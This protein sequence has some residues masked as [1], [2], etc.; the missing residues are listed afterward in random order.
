MPLW[1]I[2]L[3]VLVLAFALGVKR[4][5][6]YLPI[7]KRDSDVLIKLGGLKSGQTVIDLG[8]GDGR[9]LLAAARLGIKGIGYEIN[10]I[11]VA[12][13]RLVCWRY[14]H[15]VTIHLA[16]FW[17]VKLPPA[18][19]IYTFLLPKYMTELDSYLK[20]Q[21]KQPTTLI[22]FAFEIPGR[23]PDKHNRNTFIYHYGD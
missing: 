13:S 2:I 1:F 3:S 20:T 6:P 10:P 18:D 12:V 5:A 9:F 15:L 14:R 22:S 23:K 4:G 19:V 21:I 17:R 11:L 7:L 16:D 8:S